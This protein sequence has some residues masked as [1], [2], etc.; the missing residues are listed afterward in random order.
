MI[1]KDLPA[2]PAAMS[3]GK[4][5]SMLGL[6]TPAANGFIQEQEFVSL[7]CYCATTFGLQLLDL[8]KK[9]YPFDWT[10]TPLHGIQRCL[11]TGFQN[12]LTYK[13]WR[14]TNQHPIF[15]DSEWGGSFWHHN[16]QDPGTQAVFSRRIER[17]LALGDVPCDCPRV[18]IRLVNHT[19]EL[20][21]LV[22]VVRL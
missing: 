11:D 14:P 6:D 16:L 22:A 12:F 9:A 10:R 21:P 4:R 8:R 20:C 7:G 18:F 19:G 3:I 15:L 1:Y 13:A 2:M 5:R 17:F